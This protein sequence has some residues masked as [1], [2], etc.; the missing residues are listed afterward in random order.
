M[1]TIYDNETVHHRLKY[2]L[3]VIDRDR[4]IAAAAR[5]AGVS[6]RTMNRWRERFKNEGVAGL[7]N[8]PRGLFHPADESVRKQIIDLKVENRARSCRKIRDL[9]N[10]GSQ[11]HF[12]RQTIWRILKAAG[13]NKRIKD[14]PKF[15]RDFER[16]HPNSLWQIDYMDAIFRHYMVKIQINQ[17]S[18]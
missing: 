18:P 17:N 4:T 15:Y 7:L 16:W 5:D 9:F 14:N 12:H 13:E 10:N 11:L 6:W 3:Q 8:K 2:V 1:T